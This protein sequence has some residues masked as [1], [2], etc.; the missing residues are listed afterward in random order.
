MQVI[1]SKFRIVRL[2]EDNPVISSYLVDDIKNQ[3][4]RYR[5]NMIN[6]EYIKLK[7]VKECTNNFMVLKN[8]DTSGIKKLHHFGVVNTIDNKKY[9]EEIYYYTCSYFKD[10]NTVKDIIEQ[11]SFEEALDIIAGVCES[12]NYMHLMEKTY[13][14]LNL[15]NI[16]LIKDNNKYKTVLQDVITA[17]IN[18][19]TIND[20]NDF[21]FNYKKTEPNDTYEDIYSIG[22]L[23]LNMVYKGNTEKVRL[24]IESIK[25]NSI[26]KNMDDENYDKIFQLAIRII[27]G[28]TSKIDINYIVDYINSQFNR[29]YS[30]FKLGDLSKLNFNTGLIGREDITDTVMEEYTRFQEGTQSSDAILIHGEVGVG[31]TCIL[32]DIV[33]RFNLV[34]SNVVQ[35]LAL[36]DS[37]EASDS[38]I[39][40]I[41]KQLIA[42]A[43]KI[44]VDKYTNELSELIPQLEKTE[45]YINIDSKSDNDKRRLITKTAYFIS[46]FAKKEKIVIVMDN[47]QRLNKLGIMILE[48]L[49]RLKNKNILLI[50]TYSD[51]EYQNNSM[52]INFFLGQG[53]KNNSVKTIEIKG[54]NLEDTRAMICAMINSKSFANKLIDTIYDN[55]KG[56]PLFI[57]EILKNIFNHKTI[58]INEDGKWTETDESYKKY[59]SSNMEQIVLSQIQDISP[60]ERK[61]LNSISIFKNEAEVHIL[62]SILNSISDLGKDDIEGG[63]AELISLGIIYTYENGTGRKLKFLN[64]YLKDIMYKSIEENIKIEK[65][66]II[67][68]ILENIYI[69]N[70][71]DVE[72]TENNDDKEELISNL[73]YHF[74][75]AKNNEKLV[76]YLIVS[77]KKLIEENKNDEA[78]KV[79]NIANYHQGDNVNETKFEIL[80]DLGK[81]YHISK[82][83]MCA[84][85]TFLKLEECLKN[86]NN[87]VINN[88][89]LA[90][91]FFKLSDIYIWTGELDQAT[92]YIKKA[93]A[94]VSK[95][96]NTE[97]WL[98][99][100]VV[101]ANLCFYKDMNEEVHKICDE[102]IEVCG[103]DH[104]RRKSDFYNIR[105]LEF[106]QK[107][108]VEEAIAD[109][110]NCLKYCKL[111][112]DAADMSRALNNLGVAYGDFYGDIDKSLEYYKQASE[113]SFSVGDLSFHSYCEYNRASGYWIEGDLDK[114]LEIL[115]GITSII[116]EQL[117]DLNFE[118]GYMLLAT[119]NIKYYNYKLAN[120]YFELFEAKLIEG[121]LDN[122]NRAEI[123]GQKA[124][125]YYCM[126]H[127]ENASKNIEATLELLD[128]DESSLK[129]QALTYKS[130]IAIGKGCNLDNIVNDIKAIV[131][132]VQSLNQKITLLIMLINELINVYEYNKAKE[133]MDI[134]EALDLK[135]INV[136]NNNYLIYFKGVLNDDVE[137]GIENLNAALE[138]SRDIN[139]MEIQWKAT[140]YLGKCYEKKSQDN[141]TIFY[142]INAYEILKKII[143]DVPDKYKVGYVKR[144]P[145]QY[146]LDKMYDD[147]KMDLSTLTQINKLMDYNKKH[148]IISNKDFLMTTRKFY[149][150]DIP[151]EGKSLN[152][153]LLSLGSNEIYNMYIINSY[154]SYISLASRAMIISR[155]ENDTYEVL[156]A[157]RNNKSMS[158]IIPILESCNTNMEMEIKNVEDKYINKYVCIPIIMESK[159]VILESEKRMSKGIHKKIIVGYIYMETNRLIDGFGKATISQCKILSKVIGV[160]I[161][162][163]Q[164]KSD[165]AIDKLTGT[166][167]R[168]YLE[169]NL[170]E[171][172]QES[173]QFST[174][175]S[176]IMFDIDKFKKINDNYGHKKGDQVLTALGKLILENIRY[177][178]SIGRY[179]GEEFVVI[180]P[181]TDS[182]AA[183]KISEKLRKK[184]ENSDIFKGKP[185]RVTCS[186]GV[187]SYP[188]HGLWMNELFSKADKALYLAKDQG[189][190]KSLLWKEEYNNEKV[191]SNEFAGII[192]HDSIQNENNI[193]TLVKLINIS[194][195]KTNQEEKLDIYLRSVME[196]V[197][198][199]TISMFTLSGQDIVNIIRKGVKNDTDLNIKFNNNM[200]TKVLESG[201]GIYTIDWDDTSSI[202]I[203]TNMPIWKSIMI[204][205]I[206]DIRGNITELLYITSEVSEKEFTFQ[207]F[208]RTQLLCKLIPRIKTKKINAN[209]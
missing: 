125:Y 177:T 85:G 196:S 168:R 207:E 63:I 106:L 139:I 4:L 62:N 37:K 174:K 26:N 123:I 55:T 33:H 192:C 89:Y 142:Y 155:N 5:L 161:E 205:P 70:S 42:Q 59:I 29:N 151:E 83:L 52:F 99:I 147:C 77:S 34:R 21:L 175:L 111:K 92:K 73:I 45:E 164:T 169:K 197:G 122:R 3:N 128:T 54:L 179:G 130:I 53:Q 194:S 75:G 206:K 116:E 159:D 11:L 166:Y 18:K 10:D 9:D 148:K 13:D 31:K 120:K 152:K 195:E 2:L 209:I 49:L 201:Q 141:E 69:Q 74:H 46:D 199:N 198:G 167:T 15:K 117:V 80:S 170:K 67:A 58:V 20:D 23:L 104:I 182:E 25:N 131:K 96:E 50:G 40:D 109:F 114:V 39:R 47:I 48:N 60:V 162:K 157:T 140:F 97:K 115:K 64:D 127:I 143:K 32:K 134:L 98:D 94:I 135:N 22:V 56:N 113:K 1:N 189:R 110:E 16:L 27:K 41:L 57:T 88:K 191:K 184:I 61:I 101:K 202:D 118:F 95:E 137:R 163:I 181:N 172:L 204:V 158:N 146:L 87:S 156:A 30:K 108:R 12:I 6:E 173:K 8:I 84:I 185:G 132:P 171:Y 71:E 203:L 121:A 78:I 35:S 188:E 91:A 90:H 149:N 193:I 126:G 43:P 200:I 103:D 133:V 154:I 107:S 124:Y 93:E 81:L 190:N 102:A 100:N 19:N 186:M 187:A 65:H 208:N 180:L 136:I 76:E 86:D 24:T 17:N 36:N 119:I 82:K 105:G 160:I 51:N 44:L 144:L 66:K 7:I 176:I 14:Y 129:W 112:N 183:Y 68:N 165:S 153:V 150:A 28:N 145:I 38:A 138:I 79:L 72:N 178:D